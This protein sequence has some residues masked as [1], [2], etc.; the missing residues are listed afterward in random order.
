MTKPDLIDRMIHVY[1][2]EFNRWRYY[3]GSDNSEGK[4]EW[5]VARYRPG[6]GLDEPAEIKATFLNADT[7]SWEMRKMAKRAA[8]QAALGEA[9][10]PKPIEDAPR[11][12]TPVYLIIP[13]LDFAPIARWKLFEGGDEITGEGNVFCWVYEDDNLSSDGDGVVYED[14][15]QPTYWFPAEWKQQP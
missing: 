1:D 13:G 3:S 8:M 10:H 11:D 4:R 5:H 7:A 14:S 12:G 9:T 2:Y 15:Q 6:C